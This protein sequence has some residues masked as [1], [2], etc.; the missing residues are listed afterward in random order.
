MSKFLKSAAF[1][2]LIVVLLVF[3]AQRLVVS[4]EPA[5]QAPTFDEFVAL[6]AEGDVREATIKNESMEVEVVLTDDTSFTTGYPED[7]AAT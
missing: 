6:I 7:Y 2:I 3:V 4:S 5:S 1:P